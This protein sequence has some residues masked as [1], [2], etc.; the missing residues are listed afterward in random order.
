MS[1]LMCMCVFMCVCVCAPMYTE[2]IGKQYKEMR[3]AVFFHD[4]VLAFDD[5]DR[6]LGSVN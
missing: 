1:M 6:G 4:F 3:G 5:M 2:M